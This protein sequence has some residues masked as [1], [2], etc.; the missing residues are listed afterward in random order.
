MKLSAPKQGT[1]LV[2]LIAGGLGVLGA[3]HIIHIAFLAPYSVFLIAG[4][5]ALLVI[6]TFVKGL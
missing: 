1:W 2:A 5:W 3:Y 6:A 4:A